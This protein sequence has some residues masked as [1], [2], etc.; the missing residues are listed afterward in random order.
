MNEQVQPDDLDALMQR[1][2]ANVEARK[3]STE[4]QVI[5]P[6]NV[7]AVAA[8]ID[9]GRQHYAA[10]EI[11]AFYDVAF[12]RAAHLAIL[13]REPDG[14]VA[15][16][17]LQQLRLGDITRIDV[18]DTLRASDEAGVRG[19]RI[20][21]LGRARF[22]DNI[23]RSAITRKLAAL[24]RISRNIPRLASYMRQ[25]ISRVDLA[26]RKVQQLEG[27]LK[28]ALAARAA[29]E[30]RMLERIETLSGRVA[31]IEERSQAAGERDGD[32]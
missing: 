17:L 19:V 9:A 24:V 18:I 7:S 20:S 31:N 5:V 13:G 28:E 21:G 29:A 8:P 32:R 27:Q 26:E 14:E 1:I 11:L 15:S 4:A 6:D 30:A 10:V 22:A 16:R 12:L 23:R 2:R 25:V 3:A